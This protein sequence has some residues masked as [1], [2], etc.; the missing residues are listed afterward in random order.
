MTCIQQ[1]YAELFEIHCTEWSN[2]KFDHNCIII[3]VWWNLVRSVKQVSYMASCSVLWLT[4]VSNVDVMG[5][6]TVIV[7]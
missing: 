1:R 3:T 4:V 6:S 5:S 2:K 7:F